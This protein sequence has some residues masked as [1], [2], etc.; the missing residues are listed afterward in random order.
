MKKTFMIWRRQ[1][2]VADADAW[3]ETLTWVDPQRVL[4][5]SKPGAVRARL[6]VHG[7]NPQEA[8]RLVKEH[9]GA[10]IRLPKGELLPAD[11]NRKI[12]VNARL[13]VVGDK[14]TGQLLRK[15][16]PGV[17]TLLIPARM[18]FGSGEHATTGMVL[19][20]LGAMGKQVESST[21]LD[22][23]TGSG[24]LALT[25]RALGAKKITAMDNCPDCVRIA[26][27]NE[28]ANFSRAQIHWYCSELNSFAKPGRFSLVTAN[29]FSELLIQ[30]AKRIWNF[31]APGGTLVLSGILNAQGPEVIRAYRK[32]GA[33]L[34]RQRRRG[35]WVMLAMGK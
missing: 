34:N 14:K 17:R 24:I 11:K 28:R 9:G 3:I 33:V 18:A 12:R 22:L 5:L 4:I 20:H 2:P 27:D 32:L 13:Y 19:R 25:A 31:V 35:K 30:N 23:G 7:S 29:L 26:K 1:I 21:V 15:K 10:M 8:R 16:N 6:E